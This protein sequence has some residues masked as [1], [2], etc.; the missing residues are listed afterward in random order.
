MKS[1]KKIHY[2]QSVLK[3]LPKIANGQRFINVVIEHVVTVSKVLLLIGMAII[4]ARNTVLFV[5][6]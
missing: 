3:K 5:E 2:A 1:R 4:E 6:V